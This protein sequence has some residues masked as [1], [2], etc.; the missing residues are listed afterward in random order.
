MSKTNMN[1][2]CEVRSVKREVHC[3]NCTPKDNTK[4]PEY[5]QGSGVVA[6][7]RGVELCPRCKC[8]EVMYKDHNFETSYG[9][10]TKRETK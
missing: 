7:T 9:Y 5:Y 10:N 1:T 4:L 2:K 6:S 3:T 8:P